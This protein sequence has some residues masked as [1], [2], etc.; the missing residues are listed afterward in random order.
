MQG[1]AWQS[2]TKQCYDSTIFTRIRCVMQRC[3]CQWVLWTDI[4]KQNVA[5]LMQ[6]LSYKPLE[7]ITLPAAKFHATLLHMFTLLSEPPSSKIRMAL[8]CC[9]LRKSCIT[10]RLSHIWTGNG[11]A[12]RRPG[13]AALAFLW[14]QSGGVF[15][16]PAPRLLGFGSAAQI[17]IWILDYGL[18]TGETRQLDIALVYNTSGGRWKRAGH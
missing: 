4:L 5:L 14:A 9:S 15:L 17:C 3:L 2:Q 1:L 6:Q 12:E 16:L 18:A 11:P 13:H 10:Q 7:R 8:W